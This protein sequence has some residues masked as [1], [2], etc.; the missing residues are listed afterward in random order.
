MRK[1]SGQP[2]PLGVSRIENRI[3]FAL[4]V[5]GEK[6]CN[7][8]IYPV[9]EAEPCETFD[10]DQT[11]GEMQCLAIEDLD[12][13][14]FEYMYEVDGNIF[15]DPYARVISGKKKWGDTVPVHELRS[16]FYQS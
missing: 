2:F 3:N 6:Q 5:S 7:L 15:P 16:G 12:I 4:P 13:T 10:M 14:A 8:L 9:G 11:F 1:V